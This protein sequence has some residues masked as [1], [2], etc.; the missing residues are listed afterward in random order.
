MDAQQEN[1]LQRVEE[2]VSDIKADL[3]SVST[4]IS[5]GFQSLNE[6]LERLNDLPARVQALEVVHAQVVA[7][8]S[9]RSRTLK[10]IATILGVVVAVIGLV[11]KVALGG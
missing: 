10:G 3:S 5:L 2:T 8:R 7:V 1:R 6:K 11:L 9:N 4:Q